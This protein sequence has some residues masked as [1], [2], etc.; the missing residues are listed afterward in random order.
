MRFFTCFFFLFAFIPFIVGNQNPADS[1]EEQ[2]LKTIKTRERVNLLHQI[3]WEQA[4]NDPKKTIAYAKESLALSKKIGDSSLISTSYNR[5]GLVYDY[6]GGFELAEKNYL[7]ALSVKQLYEGKDETDGILNNLGSIYFYMG[8]YEKSMEYYLNSLEIRIQKENSEEKLKSLAQTYNNIGLLLKSQS[9]YDG[10]LK[11]YSECLTIKQKL[12]DH[13]GSITTLSNIGV[14]FMQQDSLIKANNYFNEALLVADSINDFSSKAMLY[15]NLGLIEKR[16]NEL[17]NAKYYYQ[18][19]IE[20]YERIDD[21]HGKATA[22]IN[23]SFIELELGQ[24]DQSR[25]SAIK[26]LTYSTKNQAFEVK[27]M[28]LKLLSKIETDQNPQK[29]LDYLKKY[30]E[31]NDSIKE[32]KIS[33]KINQMV[34][35]YETEKKETEIEFLKKDREIKDREIEKK[36]LILSKNKIYLVGAFSLLILL[37]I[38]FYIFILYYKSKK[39]ASEEKAEKLHEKHQREIDEI[40][41]SVERGVDE[42]NKMKKSIT[43]NKTELNK[44]LLNPLTE[45]EMEVLMLV[46]EGLTN[47]LI[48][49]KLFISVNTVKTHILKIYEK[50]DVQNRTAAAAKASSLQILSR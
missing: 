15:N 9:N 39:K 33:N 8:A 11:Y 19:S 23:L 2:L 38:V 37:V 14:L 50:L 21:K 1:L 42:Q 47:K 5:I 40:R 46:S 13:R 29:A 36:E 41:R 3:V 25:I 34:L 12:K 43:I 44:Y 49:E 27:L 20:I 17:K 26:A 45:R 35:M 10:A 24:I 31:L 4:M 16:K 48:S 18:N 7:K 22:L 28:A 6:G 30:I 32:L